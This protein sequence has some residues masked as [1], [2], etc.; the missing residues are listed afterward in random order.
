MVGDRLRTIKVVVLLDS[1]D[2]R[3]ELGKFSDVKK[4]IGI[5]SSRRNEQNE[6]VLGR[7][8]R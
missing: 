7:R 5:H 3:E 4:W 2:L 6:S 8:K 1:I